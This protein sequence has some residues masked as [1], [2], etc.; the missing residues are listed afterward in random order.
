MGFTTSVE[1]TWTF[2]QAKVYVDALPVQ[3]FFV[4]LT[5]KFSPHGS[6]LGP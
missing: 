3:T 1:T 2:D 4:F 6:W 5:M